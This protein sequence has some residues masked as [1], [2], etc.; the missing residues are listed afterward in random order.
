MNPACAPVV[1]K[2]ALP[3]VFRPFSVRTL[4]RFSRFSIS[5]LISADF[6]PNRNLLLNTPS[7]L[8]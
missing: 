5:I 8:N 1:P 3:I 7:T 4:T 2:L 6:V